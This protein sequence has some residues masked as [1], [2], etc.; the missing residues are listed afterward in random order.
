MNPRTPNPN[1][2]I[3]FAIEKASKSDAQ[4]LLC[5]LDTPT[6]FYTTR[7]LDSTQY[8]AYFVDMFAWA[9]AKDLVMPLT[10][11]VNRAKWVEMKYKDSLREA[12]SIAFA[13]QQEDM[14][15]DSETIIGRL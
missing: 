8:P 10:H 4:V 9:V 13:D 7:M 5:D 12:Y 14:P 6:L 1:Q 15:P 3:P 11:D 2:R